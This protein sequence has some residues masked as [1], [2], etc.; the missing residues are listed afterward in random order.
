MLLNM[1]SAGVWMLLASSLF[2]SVGV[3]AASVEEELE[4]R[5]FESFVSNYSKSYRH[6]PETWNQKFRVF[7]VSP[8]STLF[9]LMDRRSRRQ[10][11]PIG[12][13][14]GDI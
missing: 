4:R 7:Q 10:P 5:L 2:L 14:E 13:T 8:H 12:L 3:Q 6:Q 1:A 11:P 9:F